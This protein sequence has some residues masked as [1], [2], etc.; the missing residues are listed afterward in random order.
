MPVA[1][2]AAHDIHQVLQEPRS[3]NIAVL[4]YMANKDG[5]QSA[6]FGFADQGR[7]D[8]PNLGDAAGNTGDF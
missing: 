3:G 8:F 5:G 6:H 1:F 4:G 7:R 2:E